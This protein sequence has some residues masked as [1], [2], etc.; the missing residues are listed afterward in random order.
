[1]HGFALSGIF[2]FVDAILF[3]LKSNSFHIILFRYLS[4]I[5]SYQFFQAGYDMIL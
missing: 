5:L 3:L 2:E 1:M 4:L